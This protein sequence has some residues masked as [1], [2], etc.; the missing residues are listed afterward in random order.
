[1]SKSL[2]DI[3]RDELRETESTRQHAIKAMRD[4]AVQNPRIIKTRLDSI[5]ILKFLRFKKYSIPAAQEAIERYMVLRQGA[6]GRDYYHIET[7]SLR[8]CVKAIFDAQ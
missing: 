6:Y 8:P 3:L 5:W 2:Q 7:D 1:L 4:W